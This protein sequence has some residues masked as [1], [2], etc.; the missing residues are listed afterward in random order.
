M[1]IQFQKVPVSHSAVAVLSFPSQRYGILGTRKLL[2]G[3]LCLCIM[4]LPSALSA[5]SPCNFKQPLKWLEFSLRGMSMRP[6]SEKFL[7]LKI[8]IT[9]PA[10]VS[11]MLGTIW[12]AKNSFAV[13]ADDDD[14]VTIQNI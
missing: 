6:K 12:L 11:P 13:S 10:H 8:A 7:D 2:S 1:F 14:R 9:F 3:S 4:T 5:A